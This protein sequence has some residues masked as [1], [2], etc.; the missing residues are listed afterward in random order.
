MRWSWTGCQ[1]KPHIVFD[2]IE[3]ASARALFNYVDVINE[4]W[5]EHFVSAY[6]APPLSPS[7]IH[8]LSRKQIS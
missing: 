3:H 8:L 5:N 6:T 1:M 2:W 7:L 4:K